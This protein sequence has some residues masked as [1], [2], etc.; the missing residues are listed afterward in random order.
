VLWKKAQEKEE[1]RNGKSTGMGRAQEWE[2][3]RN[4]KSTGMGRA[5]E[6]E[7]RRNEKAP[8]ISGVDTRRR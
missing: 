6:W 3:R 5:Q 1:H 8:W 7:E 2:E 4:G